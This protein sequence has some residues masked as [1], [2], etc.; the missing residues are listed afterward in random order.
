MLLLLIWRK[1]VSF[2]INFCTGPGFPSRI[3]EVRLLP[4]L[5][6]LDC[7]AIVA[8][9]QMKQVRQPSY[10]QNAGTGQPFFRTYVLENVLTYTI[11]VTILEIMQRFSSF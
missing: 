5:L 10:F 6:N 9:T 7:G 8:T 11:F 2:H 3:L 1:T 4:E